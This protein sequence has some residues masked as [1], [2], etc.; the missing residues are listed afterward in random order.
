[1]KKILSLSIFALLSQTGLAFA[2]ETTT[3]MR[4]SG[5]HCAS[6][7]DKIEALIKMQDGVRTVTVDKDKLD[8]DKASVQQQVQDLGHK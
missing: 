4:Y 2:K 5:W 7:S 8:Q 6:C 3:T 1:M